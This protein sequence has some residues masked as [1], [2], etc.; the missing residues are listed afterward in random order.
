MKLGSQKPETLQILLTRDKTQ[1]MVDLGGGYI[2]RYI[3][4]YI[5]VY[6]KQGSQ[7]RSI[8]QCHSWSKLVVSSREALIAPVSRFVSSQ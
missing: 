5:G 8:Q 3:L 7:Y 4:Y 6:A 1:K 2:Y